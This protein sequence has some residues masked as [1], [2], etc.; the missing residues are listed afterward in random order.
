MGDVATWEARPMHES[1][2]ISHSPV[3]YN[4]PFVPV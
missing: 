3:C 2:P 4:H 1:P